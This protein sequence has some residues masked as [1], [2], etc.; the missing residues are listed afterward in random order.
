MNE[1]PIHAGRGGA[2]SR[3]LMPRR[4]FLAGCLGAAASLAI[5]GAPAAATGSGHSAG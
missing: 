2:A 4:R 5:P 3:R 1:N